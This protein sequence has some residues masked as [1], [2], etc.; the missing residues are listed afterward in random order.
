MARTKAQRAAPRRGQARRSVCLAACLVLVLTLIG[1]RLAAADPPPASVTTYH[2]DAARSGHYQVP[3]LTWAIAAQLAPDPG[4]DGQVPGNVYAQPLFFQPPGGGPGL[5]IVATEDAVVTALDAASGKTVWQTPLGMPVRDSTVRCSNISPIGVTGTP[6][7]DPAA[8]AIY[9]DALLDVPYGPRHTMFGLR[10]ADGSVL[11]GWPLDVG[12]AL[13]G[14]GIP[15]VARDQNQRAALALLHGR[16]YVAFGGQAGECGHYHGMVLG[17]ATATPPYLADAW[18]TRG[19]RGGVWAPG[20]IS[21]ADDRLYFATGNSD[22]PPGS[23]DRWSDGNAVFRGLPAPAQRDDP[24][25]FFTPANYAS[26]DEADLDLGGTVPLPVDLPDG[27]RRLIAMGK[28]GNAYLLDRDN[29][30]GIGGALA[31]RHVA[32][33]NVMT[34]PAVYRNSGQTLVVYR[35]PFALCT[36]GRVTT[37]LVAL[38]VTDAALRPLWCAPMDGRGM[39]V[40]TTAGPEA[41]PIVWVVGAEG[42]GRLHGFRGDTGEPVFASAPLPGLRHFVAPLVAASRIYVAGDGRVFAFRWRGLTEAGTP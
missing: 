12:V 33:G 25:A 14:R 13:T 41:D 22:R 26:L 39:P 21:I 19:A 10:L 15:F 31:V 24:R 8:G 42:D 18:V 9:L 34:A 36:D 35:A 3:G 1:A 38:A 32:N 37:A 20:G 29:L 5:V 17:F 4:F 23:P 7:I 16:V 28:D 30:G 40:V 27:A 2:A 6:V 11:P